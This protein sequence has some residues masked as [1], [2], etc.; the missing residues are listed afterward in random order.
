M[1]DRISTR[2]RKRNKFKEFIWLGQTQKINTNR[3]LPIYIYIYIYKSLEN[4]LIFP[5]LL[6]CCKYK[7]KD[8]TVKYTY[9]LECTWHN[10]ISIFN[11]FHR[12]WFLDN[13][14]QW[15]YN[16]VKFCLSFFFSLASHCFR[17]W[18][19]INLKVYGV[20]HCLNKNLTTHFI[21][22]LAQIWHWN[23]ANSFEQSPF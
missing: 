21:R 10:T 6:I 12:I 20:I 1:S 5:L 18:S 8:S 14:I 19:K 13:H 11:R 3:F 15:F 17:G 2:T 9:S 4:F 22:Y 23:F 7:G 16:T